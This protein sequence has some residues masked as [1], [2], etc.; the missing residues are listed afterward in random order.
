MT[1]PA[2]ARRNGRAPGM[3]TLALAD[4]TV[5][6][7]R[8]TGPVDAG[9]TVVLH[10]GWTQD[11]TTWDDVVPLLARTLRVVRYDARGHGR[12]D[13]GRSAATLDQ[14]AD[15]LADV[16]RVTAPTGRLVIA[17]HSLGG[18]VVLAFAA[19]H[20]D[21]L[22]RVD[23]LALVATSGAGIGRDILGLPGRVTGPVMHV[24]PYVL[25]PAGRLPLRRVT[26]F[27]GVLA[28]ALRIGLFGPGA[29]T[30]TNRRRT[31]A[32]VGRSH[33]PTVAALAVELVG[34][35]MAAEIRAVGS[36]P[37]AILGGT[38]DVLTPVAHSHALAA[39]LPHATL[40]IYKGAGHM[41]PYE[42][43]S[44]L[45]AEIEALARPAAAAV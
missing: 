45:V 5:V 31:A 19:R 30:A 25:G 28:P 24:A 40:T 20:P 7:Y 13:A 34:H 2:L 38:H 18:P 11:H 37:V 41:L 14:L 36:T 10:H 1:S 12:S 17:G 26:R 39:A 35:D 6:A 44:E 42:R 9:T 4:G 21:L 23:G 15:D 3:S 16:I 27:P 43:T 8:A 33:P 29:A 22:A 32:Q